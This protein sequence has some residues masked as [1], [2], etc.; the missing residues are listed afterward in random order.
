MITPT[1]QDVRKMVDQHVLLSVTTLFNALYANFDLAD[2][3]FYL[4]YVEDFESTALEAGVTFEKRP[5]GIYYVLPDNVDPSPYEGPFL[6]PRDAYESACEELPESQLAEVYE[7]WAVD[8]WLATKLHDNGETVT[9]YK[10]LNIWSRL[11]TGQEMII[12]G[13]MIDITKRQLTP[14][15]G[16]EVN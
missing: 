7:L 6:T 1:Q 4:F 14:F 2:E 9:E 11:T 5:D 16:Y 10:D 12:D 13:C 15:K 8:D 3:L